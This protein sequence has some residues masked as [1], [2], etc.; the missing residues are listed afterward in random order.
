MLMIDTYMSW[1]KPVTV[2]MARLLSEFNFY[3]YEDVLNP[4][5]LEGQAELLAV[6]D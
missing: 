1:D 4:D 3:W 6:V 5:D 2:K